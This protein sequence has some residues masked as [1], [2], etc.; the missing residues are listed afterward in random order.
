MT[1][2]VNL[3]LLCLATCPAR[4]DFNLDMHWIMPIA[5]CVVLKR[6][7]VCLVMVNV[8]NIYVTT[9]RIINFVF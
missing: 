1:L 2:L 8:A 7:A 3:S 6:F 9:T 5:L 4:P